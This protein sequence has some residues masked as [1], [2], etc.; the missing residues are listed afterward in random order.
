VELHYIHA[1]QRNLKGLGV[2]EVHEVTWMAEAARLTD[3]DDHLTLIL[4]EGGSLVLE[5]A[6]GIGQDL[7]RDAGGQTVASGRRTRSFS[8]FLG[9]LIRR[10]TRRWIDLSLGAFGVSRESSI[11]QVTLSLDGGDLLVAAGDEETRLRGVDRDAARRFLTK[12]EEI[13]GRPGR[14]PDA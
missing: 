7:Q 14:S 13:R 2:E 8:E 9:S 12:L 10:T 6:K 3:R 4:T 11:D 5:L 1:G